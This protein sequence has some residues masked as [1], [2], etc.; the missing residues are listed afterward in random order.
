MHIFWMPFA[1]D[2]ILRLALRIID[3]ELNIT[4]N[5]ATGGGQMIAALP[6]ENRDE[7]RPKHENSESD[8]AREGHR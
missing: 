5:C 8:R 2:L 4:Q 1:S 3:K 6:D 7:A